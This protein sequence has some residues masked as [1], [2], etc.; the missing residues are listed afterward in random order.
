MSF[1]GI[2]ALQP[3]WISGGNPYRENPIANSENTVECGFNMAR[4]V[5][6]CRHCR[7]DFTH[8]EIPEP[9]SEPPWMWFLDKPAIAAEGVEI[10]CPQCKQKSTY[11]RHQLTFRAT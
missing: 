11:H 6:T 10:D 2:I 8:S 9:Y 3:L 7:Q 5:F 1:R 4:W